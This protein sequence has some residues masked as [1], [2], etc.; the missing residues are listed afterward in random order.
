MEI[1][2]VVEPASNFGDLFG[3]VASGFMALL[4][5]SLVYFAVRDGE[6]SLAII[7]G[8]GFVFLTLV[9]IG[10]STNYLTPDPPKYEVLITDMSAFDT[11]KYE[12]IAQRGKIFVVE[13]AQSNAVTTR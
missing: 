10:A 12:I 11:S 7:L 3:A 9:C 8:I 4:L 6:A 2:N 1:L 5:L 13:E